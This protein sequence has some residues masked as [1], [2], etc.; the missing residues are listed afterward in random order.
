MSDCVCGAARDGIERVRG[1][2]VAA[3]IRTSTRTDRAPEEE[4]NTGSHLRNVSPCKTKTKSEHAL[5]PRD[6]NDHA[7]LERPCD[8]E[9]KIHRKQALA[10]RVRPELHG[11]GERLADGLAWRQQRAVHCVRAALRDEDIACGSVSDVGGE[12][13]G[14]G[15]AFTVFEDGEAKAEGEQERDREAV[16]VLRVGS[17]GATRAEVG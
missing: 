13:K 10:V 5:P 17:V 7:L 15:R 6:A 1:L 16:R 14:E 8:A 4:A 2:Y 3:C 12:V 11:L 9:D